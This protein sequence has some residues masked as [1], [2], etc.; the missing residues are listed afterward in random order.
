MRA[1]QGVGAVLEAIEG[2]CFPASRQ[3]LVEE[4][5]DRQ[6]EFVPG[7]PEALRVMLLRLP[8]ERFSSAE[9]LISQLETA[10]D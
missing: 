10:V 8:T 1:R 5:G 2:V 6:V 4:R 9:D 7:K 3:A